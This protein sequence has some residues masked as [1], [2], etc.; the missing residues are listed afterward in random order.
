M[1]RTHCIGIGSGSQRAAGFTL[2]ELAIVLV[3]FGILSAI[4]I[5][6]FNKFMRATELNNTVNQAAMRLR[7]ARQRAISENNNYI[8]WYNALTKDWG[9]WDDDNNDLNYQSTEK[10]DLGQTKPSWITVTNSGTNPFV[11]VLV[12]FSPNGSANQSG[13]LIY[14]NSDGY[15]RSVSVIRPTGMVTVQ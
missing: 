7:V 14:T 11:S 12:T 5:P 1:N 13:T 2:V 8:C 15:S 4:A 6:G 10:F 9:W 3:I